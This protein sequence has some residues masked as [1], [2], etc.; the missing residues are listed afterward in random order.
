MRVVARRLVQQ[1]LKGNMLGLKEIA[2]RR[3]GKVAQTQVMVGNEDA[4]M[5]RCYA[6][7]PKPCSNR[8]M[9]C[10]QFSGTP[11]NPEANDDGARH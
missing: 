9:A 4:S 7:V 10:L 1:A 8:G 3:N 5:V 2:E 6:E 11:G